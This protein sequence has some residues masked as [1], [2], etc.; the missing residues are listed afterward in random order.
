MRKVLL[1]VAVLTLGVFALAQNQETGGGRGG[2]F[3]VDISGVV[4]DIDTTTAAGGFGKTVNFFR[5][6]KS[7]MAFDLW[8][9][10]RDTNDSLLVLVRTTNMPSDTSS[11][12]TLTNFGGIKV[13]TGHSSRSYHFQLGVDTTRFVGSYVWITAYHGDAAGSALATDTSRFKVQFLQWG[14]DIDY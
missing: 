2:V 5:R 4:G 12:Q 8:I 10:T 13:A 6:A 3:D 14:D 1:L 7:N 9:Q 11:Y